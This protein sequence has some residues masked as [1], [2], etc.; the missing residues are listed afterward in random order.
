MVSQNYYQADFCGA[1]I[2]AYGK[3]R[4][5]PARIRSTWDYVKH[6]ND[7]TLAAAISEITKPIMFP[8]VEEILKICSRIYSD[9]QKLETRK[10]Q[11]GEPCFWCNNS[12]AKFVNNYAYRCRNCKLGDVLYPSF[13]K[14]NG[15]V[16]FKEKT[17]TDEDGFRFIETANAIYK[18][19][20][21]SKNIRDNSFVIK[22]RPLSQKQESSG[23]KLVKMSKENF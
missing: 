18:T 4:F 10:L 1:I 3:E 19:K 8:G 21:G 23:P 15:E 12:G 6:F 22:D 5:T 2:E 11:E 7:S 14:Y 20:P 17:W 13:P 16:E 9:N